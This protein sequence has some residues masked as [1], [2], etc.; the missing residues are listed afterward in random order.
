M[1]TW[2]GRISISVGTGVLMTTSL[3]SR[4]GDSVRSDGLRRASQKAP[5]FPGHGCVVP[6]LC[7]L[8]G[9]VAVLVVDGAGVPVGEGV[10]VDIEGCVRLVAISKYAPSSWS[11]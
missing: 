5:V 11:Q 10:V 2:N 8:G 1:S 9:E 6:P 4:C 7:G 3:V